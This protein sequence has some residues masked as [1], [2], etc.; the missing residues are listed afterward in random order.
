MSDLTPMNRIESALSGE[1]LTPMTRAEAIISGEDLEPMTR[2]E[3]FLKNN[4]GGGS[5]ETAVLT[6][7]YGRGTYTDDIILSAASF[8][9]DADI[10]TAY[11]PIPICSG[12]KSTVPVILKGSAVCLS[13]PESSQIDLTSSYNVMEWTNKN[14]DSIS[15]KD[16]IKMPKL[17]TFTVDEDT[18]FRVLF[19]APDQ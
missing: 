9:A 18:V 19:I 10:I 17:M 4:S 6:I 15:P 14:G 13:V 16:V 5:M 7:D 1:P 3:W 12:D 11:P 8:D 2:L